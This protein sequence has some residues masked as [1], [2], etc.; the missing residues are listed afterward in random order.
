MTLVFTSDGS[1]TFGGW[2][3]TLG[4]IQSG[5][6]VTVTPA[7]DTLCSNGTILLTASGAV[8]YTWNTGSTGPTL[9]VS[10]PGVYYVI[11]TTASGC[12]SYS[13]VAIIYQDTLD[14]TI[15]VIGGTLHVSSPN[16]AFN[17]AWIDCNNP[18]SPL[19]TNTVFT[20]TQDGYYALIVTNPISGCSDTS[21]CYHVVVTHLPSH[22]ISST[23][24]KLYPNPT[25]G[26]SAIE[27]DIPVTYLC[28]RN[29]QGEVI[30]TMKPNTTRIELLPHYPAGT[31]FIEIH[32]QNGKQTIL[33][34]VILQ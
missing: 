7:S 34:W 3:A 17:Y 24:V 12:S 26:I 16:P 13:N 11:G 21:S 33:R 29:P 22:F 2:R 31:Y 32:L 10:Q 6:T 25:K 18:G 27:A 4:C 8:N 5:P 20:P 9:S 19:S 15:S 14:T 30:E 23:P 28:I 1:S